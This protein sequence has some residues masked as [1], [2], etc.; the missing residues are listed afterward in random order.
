MGANEARHN[1][2]ACDRGGAVTQDVRD[3]TIPGTRRAVLDRHAQT[4]RYDAA[5]CHVNDIR[6]AR[7]DVHEGLDDAATR[8]G[9]AHAI[10]RRDE[11]ASASAR[12]VVDSFA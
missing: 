3:R 8:W 6:A 12:S 10:G 9:G 11:V 5:T 7:W 2:V 1:A 4:L